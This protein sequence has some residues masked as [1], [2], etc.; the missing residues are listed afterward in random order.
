MVDCVIKIPYWQG[1]NTQLAKADI[2]TTG[3][4]HFIQEVWD[5]YILESEDIEDEWGETWEHQV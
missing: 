1:M 5:G 3:I 4:S 2:D